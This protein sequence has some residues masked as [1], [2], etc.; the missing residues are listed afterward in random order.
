MWAEMY[1]P[2]FEFLAN[3]LQTVSP[4]SPFVSLW[5]NPFPLARTFTCRGAT[6]PNRR[7]VDGI[8]SAIEPGDGCS[9]VRSFLLRFGEIDGAEWLATEPAAVLSSP[10]DRAGWNG[11]AS[12]GRLSSEE[13]RLR[14]EFR[15]G[16]GVQARGSDIAGLIGRA[17]AFDRAAFAELYR[18]AVTPVYRYISARL[19]TVE[20][21]EEL[22]QEVFLAALSGIQGLRSEDEAG[23]MAWLF[24][25]ARHKLADHLRRR[26]RRPMAPLED[27]G[28]LETREPRPDE[29]AEVGEEKGELRRALGQIT[30]EQREVIVCKYVL[31]YDNERTA[32]TVGKNVNS[33]NQLH[34]RAIASLHRLLKSEKG[35]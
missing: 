24:Q 31:G 27:A 1:G 28:E 22:T 21:A 35:G 10:E 26:Y 20:E 34:H 12:R 32:R 15:Q 7:V 3:P 25:I 19:N 23:F 5:L 11:R 14:V 30:D 33:V 6:L 8:L 13:T 16:E 2:S 18:L 29:Q 4:Y 17:R 9:V